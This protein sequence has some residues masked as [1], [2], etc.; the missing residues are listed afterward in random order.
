MANGILSNIGGFA[1]GPSVSFTPR[2]Q[3]PVFSQP[4]LDP[5]VFIDPARV[6]ALSARGLTMPPASAF[7]PSSPVMGGN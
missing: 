4:P 5:S 7:A 1:G 3:R 6:S 2:V